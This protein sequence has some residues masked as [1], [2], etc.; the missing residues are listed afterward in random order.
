MGGL[1][2]TPEGTAPPPPPPTHN[3]PFFVQIFRRK[4]QQKTTKNCTHLNSTKLAIPCPLPTTATTPSTILQCKTIVEN[5]KITKIFVIP[6]RPK[7]LPFHSK[8]LK[9]ICE[10]MITRLLAIPIFCVLPHSH[11]FSSLFFIF[12]LNL[13]FASKI[14]CSN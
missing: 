10:N 5:C 14:Q 1:V 4:L 8:R 2:R 12:F 3:H 7:M 13:K 6:V 11:F 9:R